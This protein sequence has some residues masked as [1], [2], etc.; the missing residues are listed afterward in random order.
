MKLGLVLVAAKSSNLDHSYCH[1]LRS[2]PADL[3]TLI[4]NARGDF[5][6]F[7]NSQMTTDKCISKMV[8]NDSVSHQ[9]IV[10]RV[11]EMQW[12]VGCEAILIL[13]YGLV[14]V[15]LDNNL[16]S[17]SPQSEKDLTIVECKMAIKVL[18]GVGRDYDRDLIGIVSR[19]RKEG[20]HQSVLDTADKIREFI[21]E[22]NKHLVWFEESI[23]A[24]YAND[25]K[26]GRE[27]C[28][29]LL[30]LPTLEEW[31]RNNVQKNL[32]FY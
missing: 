20:L 19:L 29:K 9:D 10:K 3:Q 6:G 8:L 2:L 26:R 25:K 18:T 31:M 30:E 15:S 1:Q 11:H 23:S 16:I 21:S 28:Q 7:I 17:L 32:E 14:G 13:N 24:Y 27:V 12:F 5:A 4:W 22:R